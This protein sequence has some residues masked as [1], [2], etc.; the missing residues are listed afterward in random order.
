MAVK[1]R[2]QGKKQI[3]LDKDLCDKLEIIAEKNRRSLTN[4][5]I[6]FCEDALAKAED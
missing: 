4:Q 2:M 5:V 3:R 6:V 1:N